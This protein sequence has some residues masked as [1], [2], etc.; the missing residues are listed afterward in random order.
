[1]IFFFKFYFIDIQL[2]D[3]VVL[4]SAVQQSDSVT[5][6]HTFSFIFF[7]I[8]VYRRT[9]LWFPVMYRRTLLFA[10]PVY[11]SLH[12]LMLTSPSIC[13]RALPLGGDVLK[14]LPELILLPVTPA[15]ESTWASQ[16]CKGALS[17]ETGPERAPHRTSFR[18]R[19][20]RVPLFHTLRARMRWGN[21]GPRFFLYQCS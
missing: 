7:S 12:L 17:T 5:H 20:P 16:I 10:H 15:N 4:I 2:I 8:L 18:R 3:S 9:L 6:I 1:M 11:N 21:L 19:P 14:C 13:L